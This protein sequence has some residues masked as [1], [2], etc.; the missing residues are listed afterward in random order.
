MSQWVHFTGIAGVTTGQLAI[1]MKQ[2][3]YDVTGSDR[4]IFPPISTHIENNGIEIQLGYKSEHLTRSFYIDKY[5][6]GALR[7]PNEH[8]DFIIT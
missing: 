4:G 8:P 7:S 1:A 6:E 3:G 2:A 5:G